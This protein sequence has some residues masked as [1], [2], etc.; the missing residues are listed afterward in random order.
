ML[1]PFLLRQH[2]VLSNVL[3]YYKKN[4]KFRVDEQFSLKL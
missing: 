2:K 1:L 4:E 3:Y